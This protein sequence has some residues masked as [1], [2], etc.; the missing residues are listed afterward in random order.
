MHTLNRLVSLIA[1][2]QSCTVCIVQYTPTQS[3]VYLLL[4]YAVLQ[5]P[6]KLPL[7]WYYSHPQ[8]MPAM[9]KNPTIKHFN[10]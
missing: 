10:R 1:I 2:S 9:P 6:E 4:A 5:P 8:E 7:S 3:R